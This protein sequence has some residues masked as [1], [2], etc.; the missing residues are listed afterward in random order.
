MNPV[1][2]ASLTGHDVRTLY[3]NYAG[4]VNP[5][6]LPDLLPVFAPVSEVDFQADRPDTSE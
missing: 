2:I 6:Q 3:E 5:P 1:A 4:L